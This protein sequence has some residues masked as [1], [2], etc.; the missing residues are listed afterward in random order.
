VLTPGARADMIAVC[1]DDPAFVPLLDDE[2]LIEHLVWSA[3]S[4]LVT[5]VW[6]EGRQVVEGGRCLT[7]DLEEARAE[8][9][10]RARRLQASVGPDR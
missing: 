10:Q 7:V 8:V 3:S 9:E 6:V 1:L 5:D 2:Q 4:R